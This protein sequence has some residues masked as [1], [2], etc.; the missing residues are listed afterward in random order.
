M[1]LTREQTIT[2][3]RK[4]WK[5]ISRQIMKDYKETYSIKTI[6]SYKKIYLKNNF[7]NEHISN[8]CFCC[9]Y[10]YDKLLYN[11]CSICP[12]LCY[13]CPLYWN[14]ENT[15]RNCTEG[16]YGSINKIFHNV[17][18]NL[19]NVDSVNEYMVYEGGAKRLSRMAYKIAML[20]ER[21]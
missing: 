8:D 6:V 18:I 12:R 5:W 4:M 17:T 21:Q 13:F 14:A 10:A 19:V 11:L 2:E 7:K 15:E 9:N 3:H 1:V 16:Y 20:E